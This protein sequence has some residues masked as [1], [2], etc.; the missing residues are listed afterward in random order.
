MIGLQN[1]RY[2]SSD[3][4][5]QNIHFDAIGSKSLQ[6]QHTEKYPYPVPQHPL[7]TFSST[8]KCNDVP[9]Q[10]YNLHYETLQ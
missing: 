4:Q 6:V 9:T 3:N 8:Q 5:R 10:K 7:T 1:H 2:L